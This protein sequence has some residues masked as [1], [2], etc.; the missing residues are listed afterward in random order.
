MWGGEDDMRRLALW[1]MPYVMLMLH[2][3]QNNYFPGG[4]S[5]FNHATPFAAHFSQVSGDGGY[6]VLTRCLRQA[7]EQGLVSTRGRRLCLPG[8]CQAS[9]ADEP[10]L[11]FTPH[12]SLML[13]RLLGKQARLVSRVGLRTGQVLSPAR[14]AR[15]PGTGRELEEAL[16]L[17]QTGVLADELF[18]NHDWAELLENGVAFRRIFA[19]LG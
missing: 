8:A 2:Y 7:E 3:R 10:E 12:G 17:V 5:A 9:R 19:P 13:A 6:P 1:G 18:G 15:L 14:W 16:F 11:R 4:Y